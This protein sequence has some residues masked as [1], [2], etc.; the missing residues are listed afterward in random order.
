[1]CEIYS[2]KC[3]WKLQLDL[4]YIFKL[5]C[6]CWVWRRNVHFLRHVDKLTPSAHQRSL[7]VFICS[8]SS[9]SIF[10]PLN[11][12]LLTTD[13]RPSISLLI[14]RKQKP[15]NG[16]CWNQKHN[17]TS[18][19]PLGG[20]GVTSCRRRQTS[21]AWQRHKSCSVGREWCGVARCQ[22]CCALRAVIRAHGPLCSPAWFEW[23]AF[24]IVFSIKTEDK[25]SQ[26][27]T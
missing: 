21:G 16:S 14:E 18:L 8:V 11:L 10:Y 22:C 27:V 19:Q 2:C 15:R 9:K 6:N 12:S 17:C 23:T 24:S 25:V 13:N 3:K 7:K 26:Q 4:N 20:W 1:M 5:I